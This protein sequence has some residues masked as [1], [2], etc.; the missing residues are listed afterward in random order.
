[1]TVAAVRRHRHGTAPGTWVM[2]ASYNC[3]PLAACCHHLGPVP[4]RWPSFLA[5]VSG[6]CAGAG[7]P[8]VAAQGRSLPSP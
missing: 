1:M 5:W 7:R 2:G 4:V 8:G 6:V 3:L